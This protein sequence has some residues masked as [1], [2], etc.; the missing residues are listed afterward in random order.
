MYY[1]T[2]VITPATTAIPNHNS[3]NP[4]IPSLLEAPPV[5]CTGNEVLEPPLLSV[6]EGTGTLVGLRIT[7]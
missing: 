4:P 1:I 5:T 2:R 3:I 7:T 6:G